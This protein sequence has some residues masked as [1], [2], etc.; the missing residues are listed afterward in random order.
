MRRILSVLAGWL[1]L[2]ASAHAQVN[3]AGGFFSPAGVSQANSAI[4]GIRQTFKKDVK[5][6]TFQAI[7]ANLTG[8]AKTEGAK[9]FP[10]WAEHQ[11]EALKL[12]GIYVLICKNPSK[13]EVVVDKTTIKKAFP[14]ANREKLAA[15]LLADFKEKAFDKG[16]AEAVAQIR[17]GLEQNLGPLV[18]TAPLNTVHD[19]AGLFSPTAIVR[20][21]GE[22]KEFKDRFKKDLVIETFTQPPP[23]QKQLLDSGA[24]KNKVF[25]DWLAQR[26]RILKDDGIHILICKDPP[27]IQIGVS[28]KTRQGMFR[29][30]DRDQLAKILVTHFKAKDFDNGL[31]DVLDFVY[32]KVDQH[33]SAPLPSPVAGT[34]LDPGRVYPAATVTRLTNDLAAIKKDL[35]QN[36]SIETF[37]QPPPGKVKQLEA[38]S[39]EA[40]DQFFT[41]WQAQ[42][43]K[44]AGNPAIHVLIVKN[45]ARAEVVVAEPLGKQFGADEQR[46]VRGLL[47]NRLKANMPEKGLEEAVAYI[48]DTLPA[49]AIKDDGGFFSAQAID[50]GNAAIRALNRRFQKKVLVETFPSIPADKANGVDLGNDE[51]R[52]QLLSAWAQERQ[53]ARGM[54]GISLL[55]CKDPMSL[56]VATG[57]ETGIETFSPENRAQLVKTVVAR[58]REKDF[59]GGLADGLAYI[60]ETLGKNKTAAPPTPG[61]VIAGD[62][63][64]QPKDASPVEKLR[65]AASDNTVKWVLI[66]VAGL[67]GLWVLIGILRALSGAGRTAPPAPPRYQNTPTQP[68]ALPPQGANPNYQPQGY[69]PPRPGMYAPPTPG[70]AP[71]AA[72]VYP[73]GAPPAQGGGGFLPSML[74]GMFG[75]AAGGWLNNRLGGGPSTTTIQQHFPQPPL[76]QSPVPP[77]YTGSPAKPTPPASPGY[78][79][80]GGDFGPAE[81]QN[82][83][84]SSGGDFGTP[85]QGGDYG[86][87]GGDFG[88]PEQTA[89]RSDDNAGS[90][91]GDWGNNAPAEPAP[92]ADEPAND[93]GAAT[94][95]DWGST[96]ADTSGGTSGSSPNADTGG[97]GDWGGGGTSGGDTGGGGGGGD[98]G[99]GG[100]TNG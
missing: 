98:W 57:A 76:P 54:D 33:V 5:I 90:T 52:N 58:F 72:P 36:V 8:K 87:S 21:N 28:D 92:S 75:A 60:D 73:V 96:G 49:P 65:E 53:R 7:P 44:A 15:T 89:S 12:D 34:V 84:T 20:T 66:G 82:Q 19:H 63:E 59:D 14:Q 16:L 45:P 38:M 67:I 2:G 42:R 70:Y 88:Q 41:A 18:S 77:N 61:K 56:Q 27:H 4:Q 48:R 1:L 43:I 80:S 74:G 39:P 93:T 62:P 91:G 50:K 99:G 85:A 30:E 47:L 69:N 26:D 94:G 37:L 31:S 97:G 95:G 11:A 64:Q 81:E 9:F 29:D 51:A 3:D 79:S 22:I 13:L 6:E 17:H 78:T 10:D 71:P 46:E 32:D 25:N 100:D 35:G 83:Y 86:T 24:D 68:M 23:E 40:Q 55:I